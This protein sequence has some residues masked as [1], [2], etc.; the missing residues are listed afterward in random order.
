MALNPS[1]D[2]LVSHTQYAPCV[3]EVPRL[4][5]DEERKT[6]MHDKDWWVEEHLEASV[7]IIN[8]IE[9]P[10]S[11][12]PKSHNFSD[13]IHE[14]SSGHRLKSTML[15]YFCTKIASS[16]WSKS[17]GSDFI[18]IRTTFDGGK[19]KRWEIWWMTDTIIG[20]EGGNKASTTFHSTIFS[21]LQ[22]LKGNMHR[23]ASAV[24]T[25]KTHQFTCT[26]KIT[27]NIHSWLTF[28]GSEEN[29]TSFS[30]PQGGR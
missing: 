20:S 26:L 21:V 22:L 23:V 12:Q 28:C 13:Q 24:K 10:A 14:L 25:C 17:F 30:E 27:L 6:L 16:I 1:T 5:D 18:A 9:F 15:N 3:S 2:P 8:L 29:E 11:A 4:E 19:E 7:D